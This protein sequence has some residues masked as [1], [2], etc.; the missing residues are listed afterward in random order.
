MNTTAILHSDRKFCDS[1]CL[2]RRQLCCSTGVTVTLRPGFETTLSYTNKKRVAT[3]KVATPPTTQ[4]N[5]RLCPT[6]LQE[7]AS[8]AD[9]RVDWNARFAKRAIRLWPLVELHVDKCN[10]FRHIQV[11]DGNPSTFAE[12]SHTDYSAASSSHSVDNLARRT[13]RIENIFHH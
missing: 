4:K 5:S 8:L 13:T 11:F 12:S 1:A 9:L 7:L 3:F 10:K 2:P 6:A